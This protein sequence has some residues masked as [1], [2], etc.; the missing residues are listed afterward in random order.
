MLF[1][2]GMIF[3]CKIRIDLTT[4]VGVYYK[5][6]SMQKKDILKFCFKNLFWVS[7]LGM[8]LLIATLA[9][10]ATLFANTP[11]SSSISFNFK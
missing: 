8:V 4:L 9:A 3:F 11:S 1:K 2:K 10:F 5:D 6:Q 7:M